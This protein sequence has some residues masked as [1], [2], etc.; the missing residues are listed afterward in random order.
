MPNDKLSKNVYLE[1][2]RSVGQQIAMSR[3][4][5]IVLIY[6]MIFINL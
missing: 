4:N 1:M 2:T 5:L 6:V 3:T